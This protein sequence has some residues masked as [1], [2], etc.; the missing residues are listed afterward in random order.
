[1][2][3]SR[4]RRTR[5]AGNHAAS[6]PTARRDTG[7]TTRVTG[8][9]VR[10]PKRNPRIKRPPANEARS[11][12][13]APIPTSPS[14]PRT[15]RRTTSSLRAPRESRIPTSRV[16]RA[17]VKLTMLCFG[18]S[19]PRAY[20][21]RPTLTACSAGKAPVGSAST[22]LCVSTER[23]VPASNGCMLLRELLH[24]HRTIP[25]SPIDSPALGRMVVPS[26]DS[27][28]SSHWR[29]S[30]DSSLRL[31]C[32]DIAI[33]PLARQTPPTRCRF[34]FARPRP[35]AVFTDSR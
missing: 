12:T 24:S 8:S 31:E 30:P 14:P 2:Q 16:R 10:I 29:G 22:P 21:M 18:I 3:P 34:P 15:M 32:T 11:R 19:V 17:T 35:L 20:S 7:T 1:M 33:M 26:C 25:G 6:P 4:H 23:T 27:R 28:S 5:R 13:N 9:Q